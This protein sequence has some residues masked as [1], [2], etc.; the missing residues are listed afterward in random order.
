[1]SKNVKLYIERHPELISGSRN[2]CV[3]DSET[4]SE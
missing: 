4:S 1:V 3:K 2:Q